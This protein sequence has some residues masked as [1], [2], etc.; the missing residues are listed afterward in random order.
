MRQDRSSNDNLR[1]N[2]PKKLK[3]KITIQYKTIKEIMVKTTTKVMGQ[4]THAS[5]EKTR[6]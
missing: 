5:I 3:L 4:P 6:N 2:G 1:R